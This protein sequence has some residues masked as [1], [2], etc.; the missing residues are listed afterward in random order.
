MIK[1][2]FKYS[3]ALS[4]FKNR[5]IL[6]I[7]CQT[8][9][10]FLYSQQIME[11]GGNG[12]FQTS[13]STNL[14]ILNYNDITNSLIRIGDNNLVKSSFGY[15]GIDGAFKISTASTLGTNDFTMASNGK[16]GIN[17]L[18]SDHRM[19][20]LHNSTSGIAGSAQLGLK[21][22]S[23]SDFSRLQFEN[24]GE[25]GHFI[26]AARATEGQALLHI[27]YS[28]GGFNDANI[29]SFDGDGFRVGVHTETPEAYIHLRQE[30]AGIDALALQNSASTDKWGM[31]IGDEDILI[32]YNGGIRGGFDVSTGNYN[33]F[34]P[35]SATIIEKK[36]SNNVLN[37][38]M[39][40]NFQLVKSNAH[41]EN[42]I[43]DPNS[44][45]QINPELVTSFKGQKYKSL[46][47]NE[48]V[49]LSIEAIQLRQKILN[50]NT[51]RIQELKHNHGLRAK[52]LADLE[53]NI[54]LLSD[55]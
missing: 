23:G 13:S 41:Q 12:L 15:N 47:Y 55:M 9:I 21:T 48:L 31:R 18:P 38:I 43:L 16:V 45:E 19:L 8:I 37:Q 52:R 40:M 7:L 6:L 34:P 35:T 4:M 36:R 51:Q 29:M 53:K 22:T 27:Y 30:D 20:I 33:N 54:A 26:L 42:I 44:F 14:D 39:K 5:I 28:D 32:Y 17:T 2:I 24:L 25:P 46:N 3:K 49:I 1:Q 11:I 50:R 10:P